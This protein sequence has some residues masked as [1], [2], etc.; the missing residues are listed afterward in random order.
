V[1][2]TGT[3]VPEL[4]TEVTRG[5]SL[6]PEHRTSGL[7]TGPA[8]PESGTAG[9]GVETSV[10]VHFIPVRESGT[11]VPEPGTTRSQSFKFEQSLQILLEIFDAIV[12][13]HTTAGGK[14]LEPK[15]VHSS[16]STRLG[17]RDPRLLIEH[18]RDLLSHLGFG[19][20]GRL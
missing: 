15:T 6:V 3:A 2:T 8:V 16:Q 18:Q 10:R 5:G 14:T 1:T 7:R 4:A 9:S 19:H 17:E 12:D 13:R 20:S 11:S